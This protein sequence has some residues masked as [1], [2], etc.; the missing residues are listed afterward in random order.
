[1]A[2]YRDRAGIGRKFCI[3]IL[4]Y[5]DRCGLTRRLGD[6]RWLVARQAGN[7]SSPRA[8]G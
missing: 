4:E 7:G 3:D 5:F 2:D 8:D 6:R 1:V